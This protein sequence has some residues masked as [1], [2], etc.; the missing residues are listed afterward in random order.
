MKKLLVV[1]LLI[2]TGQALEAQ[3]TSEKDVAMLEAIYKESLLNGN[4][5]NWLD[6]LS[7]KIGGRLSGSINA[8]KAVQYTKEE[9]EKLGLDR[10]WLQPVMV[11]K[12]VRGLKEYS[13]METGPGVTSVMNIC[14]L[15]GSVATPNAGLKANV[16]EVTSLEELDSLGSKNI[17]GKI[18]FFNRPMRAD[19]IQTF[20]AYGG[21][22]DQ[23]YSGAKQAAKY[24]WQNGF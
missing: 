5:Y 15:G 22:V 14:A 9:L 21:C 16:V 20:E 23:R 2:F 6:H 24:P 19:L 12:W 11:P 13:F 1:L 17:K 4:S 8:Q 7:N 10:V 18:V 3:N